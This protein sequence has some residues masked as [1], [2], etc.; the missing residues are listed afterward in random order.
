MKIVYD[1]FHPERY[2]KFEKKDNI[3]KEEKLFFGRRK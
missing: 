2:L 3:R 1:L